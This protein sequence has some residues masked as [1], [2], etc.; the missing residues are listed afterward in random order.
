[1]KLLLIA[2]VVSI[3]K[4]C[5]RAGPTSVVPGASDSPGTD[6]PLHGALRGPLVTRTLSKST[7]HSRNGVTSSQDAAPP[8]FQLGSGADGSVDLLSKVFPPSN[9]LRL[10]R[11]A[12]NS[13]T[14][15][16]PVEQHDGFLLPHLSRKLRPHIF[17]LP[18][19]FLL[20]S[21]LNLFENNRNSL[22]RPP[23]SF[24]VTFSFKTI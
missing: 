18:S 3:V 4:L 22:W 9:L 10:D 2:S 16:V 15:A 20:L 13:Q 1:M 7:Y 17:V 6:G 8:V 14:R 19:L 11:A 24:F 23:A 21:K 12:T 5:I